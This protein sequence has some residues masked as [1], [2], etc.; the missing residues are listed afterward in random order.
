MVPSPQIVGANFVATF[1]QPVGVT[2]ITYG[3]EWSSTLDVG[4]W[5]PITDTGI[6]PQHIFSLPIG[7]TTKRFVRLKVSEP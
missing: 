2:G 3:A 6:A 5:T 7:S 1:N 4:S